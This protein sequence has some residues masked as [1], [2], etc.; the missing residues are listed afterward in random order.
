MSG[1]TRSFT[2]EQAEDLQQF[3]DEFGFVVIRDVLTPAECDGT[4]DAIWASMAVNYLDFLSI[5][6]KRKRTIGICC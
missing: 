3:F 4:V 1:F 5:V 2:L 6:P